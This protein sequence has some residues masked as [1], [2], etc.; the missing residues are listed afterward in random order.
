MVEAMKIGANGTPTFVIG[1]S[2][3]DGV[4]G[5]VVMG[6]LPFPVFEEKLKALEK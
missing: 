3:P 1:K 6:A 2:L 5:E 4:E